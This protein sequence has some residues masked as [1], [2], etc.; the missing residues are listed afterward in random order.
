MG[1]NRQEYWSGLPFSSLEDLLEPGIKPTSPAWKE[2]LG[3]PETFYT[4]R[5]TFS[6]K[7][8]D[9]LETVLNDQNPGKKTK[10]WEQT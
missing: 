10:R 6:Q 9:I 7:L 4:Y 5:Q 3:K 2:P 8:P 1:F